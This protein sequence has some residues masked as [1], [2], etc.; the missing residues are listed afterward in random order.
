MSGLAIVTGQLGAT[1]GTAALV[2]EWTTGKVERIALT[3]DSKQ[4]STYAAT[5]TPF[6]TGL[7]SPFGV[8]VG[9]DGAL[10]VGDWARGTIYR[11][12]TS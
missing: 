1:T 10:F 2:A 8:V 5:V 12:A 6:L 4:G 9:P 3:K 7:Q 11:I